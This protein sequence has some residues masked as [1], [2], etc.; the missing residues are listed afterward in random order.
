VLSEEN[1]T[2]VDR[3][4]ESHPNFQLAEPK[5]LPPALAPVLDPRGL[6][7]CQPHINDSD[8][9]FAARLERKS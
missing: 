9:F 6:M 7:R 5:T 4:L 2:I 1:E 8:G 3:F